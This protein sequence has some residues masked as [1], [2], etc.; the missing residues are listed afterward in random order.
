[1]VTGHFY[2]WEVGDVEL[3]LKVAEQLKLSTDLGC[4][5]GSTGEDTLTSSWRRPTVESV[6]QVEIEQLYIS[7]FF[8]CGSNIGAGSMAHS[9]RLGGVAKATCYNRGTRIKT[10]IYVSPPREQKLS[11]FIRVFSSGFPWHF[12][13]FKSMLISL[14][15]S[16]ISFTEFR[17]RSGFH[18]WTYCFFWDETSCPVALLYRCLI[19]YQ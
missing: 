7:V 10:H 3:G 14:A 8:I 19:R 17:P 13:L 1:M 15:S 9:R 16:V 12:L 5:A 4:W 18:C 11:L 6:R 2:R